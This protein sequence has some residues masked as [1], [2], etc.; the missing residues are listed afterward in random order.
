LVHA[1]DSFVH[2]SAIAMSKARILAFI[3]WLLSFLIVWPV[4]AHAQ[5]P[6]MTSPP[7][8]ASLVM[9]NNAS[10]TKKE[11]ARPGK[12]VHIAN[13]IAKTPPCE[14]M[15]GW[16]RKRSERYIKVTIP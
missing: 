5:V 15:L 12:A 13:F 14:K 10:E 4:A 6:Q 8:P 3:L 16:L 2:P 11:T 9:V 1:Q 7:P